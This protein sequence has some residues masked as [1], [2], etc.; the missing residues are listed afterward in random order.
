MRSSRDQ[1]IRTTSA[2]LVV[3]GLLALAGCGGGGADAD[4][5][6]GPS[7]SPSTAGST[8]TGSAG[9]SP[10]P[11]AAAATGKV[12][13]SRYF[14]ARA[15]EG[16]DVRVVS[17]DFALS[18]GKGIEHI[19]IGIAPVGA[20][21]L[22]LDRQ[23]HIAV[24]SAVGFAHPDYLDPVTLGGQPAWKVVGGSGS[25]VDG[26]VGTTRDGHAVSVLVRTF[27][28]RRENEQVLRSVVASF[29]W[30]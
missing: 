21:Q 12:F 1:T 18:A 10:T 19:D 29:E 15:P 22:P 5:D 13:P 27:G 26:M 11:G 8:P 2:A 16:W 14:T 3:A 24:Q 17:K 6:P 28:S 9:D 23:A 30:K 20:A 4:A 7:P 25:E